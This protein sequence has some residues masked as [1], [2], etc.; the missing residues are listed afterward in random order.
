MKITTSGPQN[1]GQI[2]KHFE[3]GYLFLSPEEYQRESA[4]K[5]DQKKLLI[6]SIFRGLDIPKFYL[7]K[8]DRKTL[9]NGYPDSDSRRIYKEIIERRV[10]SNEEEYPYIYEVVDGQQRIRTVL[11]YMGVL[12][13]SEDVLRGIWLT[14]YE[15]YPDTPIAKGKKFESLNPDQQTIF[16]EKFLTVMILEDATIDEIREMFL[17]LQNGTPLNA[18][19]KRDAMG[20]YLGKAA[21][22]LA[23][24]D[25]FNICVNFDNSFSAFNLVASQMLNLEIKEKLFSCTSKQLDAL[26]KRYKSNHIE[27]YIFDKSKKVISILG[28]IFNT[29]SYHLNRSYAL[30]LY[31]IISEII[32]VY[33]I[34]ANEYPKIR[35][36]FEKMDENRLIAKNRDY[37]DSENDDI[38]EDLSI[39]MSSGTDGLDAISKRHFI[40]LQFIFEGVDLILLPSLDPQRNFT[41]E[42]KLILYRR[43]KGLCQLEHNGTICGKSIDF[44]D[45]VVD[46]IIPHSLGGKTELKN[47][48]IS[49][50]SCNIARGNR[51]SFDPMTM[52]R[53][54]IPV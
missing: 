32:K 16:E 6:D 41:Y 11:E 7:W 28:R 20:S 15:T 52:C 3:R 37:S 51:D 31:W 14:P 21:Y 19:Q 29:K 26:Y 47:G 46:H 8:I 27:Q 43:S 24:L 1:I 53:L 36:N 50:N 44:D 33:D 42:E 49:Y 2:K 48:R 38:Y 13:P 40:I 35:E 12:P 30:S 5:L 54:D 4:W 22:D 45:A 25:F 23:Q 9:L 18:Q 39:S 34:E 10:I 17:R